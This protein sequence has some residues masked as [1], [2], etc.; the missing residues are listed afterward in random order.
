L[1]IGVKQGKSVVVDHSTDPV[2]RRLWNV[3]VSKLDEIKHRSQT[4]GT[5][6]ITEQA[7][8]K[9]VSIV[10]LLHASFS[11]CFSTTVLSLFCCCINIMFLLDNRQPALY[12]QQTQVVIIVKPETV[13]VKSTTHATT[14]DIVS[15]PELAM[16]II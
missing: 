11:P 15:W 1:D 2:C 16:T 6:V 12:K 9:R 5:Y 7:G 14:T 4:Q 8:N 10:L 13:C 3:P